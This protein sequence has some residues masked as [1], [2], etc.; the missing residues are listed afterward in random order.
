MPDTA[1]INLKPSLS[2]QNLE[3]L[4]EM[5]AEIY[6]EAG[7]LEKLVPGLKTREAIARLLTG[8]NSYYSNLIEGVKTLPNEVEAALQKDI[9]ADP[10]VRDQQ[11]LSEAHV[12]TDLRMQ[13]RL[14]SEPDLNIHSPQFLTWLHSE[15]YGALPESLRLTETLSGTLL[16][17]EP[18]VLRDRGVSV[19]RHQPPDAG[20]LPHILAA[21][22]TYFGQGEWLATERLIAAASAHHRLAWIHPFLD[23][24]GRVAR[25][26]SHAC[27]IRAK[28]HGNGLW[29]LSRGLARN[30]Q[31]YYDALAAADET[32]P[33][34]NRHRLS[35]AGLGKF[36]RFFLTTLLDQI[37]FMS[38]LLELPS[39]VKRMES[40]VRF[41]LTPKKHGEALARL[42][43]ALFIEGEIT[44]GEVK[45]I[46]G[47]RDTA[48]REVIN[49][50]FRHRL[51]QSPSPKGALALAFPMTVLDSYFPRLYLDLPV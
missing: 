21:F 36:A 14:A 50:A 12:K 25:L 15:F 43:K 37:R 11:K 44:R 38:D 7:S 8:M 45:L 9:S 28:V 10:E 34:E 4:A 19:G 47:L 41:E 39:M 18:G 17:I 23:G 6:R 22:E 27:L 5:T 32:E 1:P 3:A 48:A 51:I 33:F 30:R 16:P 26:Y 20:E 40:Y 49:L 31:S 46:T 24:N 2:P 13:R 29:S 42:L 35:E